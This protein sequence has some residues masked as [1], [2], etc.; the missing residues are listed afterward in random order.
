[1]HRNSTCIAVSDISNIQ[2]EYML[3][4]LPSKA[5]NIDIGFISEPPWPAESATPGVLRHHQQYISC[6]KELGSSFL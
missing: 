2:P 3:I 5:K 4:S 6:K 1:M